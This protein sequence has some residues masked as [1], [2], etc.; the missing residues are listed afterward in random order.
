MSTVDNLASKI[1]SV[2][3]QGVIADSIKEQP[4][5]VQTILTGGVSGVL[6]EQLKEGVEDNKIKAIASKF[7][8]PETGKEYSDDEVEAAQD[9]FSSLSKEEQ[10]ELKKAYE[11]GIKEMQDIYKYQF[12]TSIVA[13]PLLTKYQTT[14]DI[15]K[16]LE[17]H[18]EYKE[19]FETM[20]PIAQDYNNCII[21]VVEQ[22]YE[23]A[24]ISEK[25]KLAFG[26]S[27]GLEKAVAQGVSDYTIEYMEENS[28]KEE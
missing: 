17:E 25:I 13:S 11:N 28:Q 26:T 6:A 2:A 20:G 14:P 1:S 21:D 22:Y 23:N 24:S 8:M 27:S 19:A 16:F 9:K 12:A 3:T 18:P 7:T 4:D 5:L 15:D 10:E